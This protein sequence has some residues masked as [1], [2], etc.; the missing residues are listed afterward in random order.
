MTYEANYFGNKH[1]FVANEAFGGIM[2]N[3]P[4]SHN[5]F[6]MKRKA[7]ATV[8][9]ACLSGKKKALAA[10]IEVLQAELDSSSKKKSSKI[11]WKDISPAK[12]DKKDKSS[13]DK[14]EE[15]IFLG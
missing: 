2:S 5:G 7:F 13:S 8:L 6:V 1:H 3:D 10:A 4:K 11:K 14:I 12:K 15:E 9:F